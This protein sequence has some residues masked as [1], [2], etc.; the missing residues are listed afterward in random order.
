MTYINV[1][2]LPWIE[3]YRPHKINDILLEENVMNEIN[4]M[5]KNRNIPNMII[6][7][8]S[9]IGK[10][11][12]LLCIASR[13]YGKYYKESVLEINASDERGIKFVQDS[14][15]VFCKRKIVYNEKD[16]D[17]YANH[18]LIILDEADNITEKAQNII[19]KLIDEYNN[20]TKFVFTSNKSS[21]IIESIQSKCKILMFSQIKY[22][23]IMKRLAY[24]LNKE[25]IKY[26]EEGLFNIAYMS[27]GDLRHAINLTQLIFNSFGIINIENVNK[28]NELPQFEIIKNLLLDCL[29]NKLL[30][31]LNKI[32]ELKQKGFTGIDIL[33]SVLNS[34]IILNIYEKNKNENEKNKNI[35]NEN[36]NEKNKMKIIKIT[37]EYLYN[38]SKNIDTDLQ[39]SAYIIELCKINEKSEKNNKNNI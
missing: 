15:T 28:I 7:G 31:S 8:I 9:G 37:C 35:K 29:N 25:E 27:Q 21:C 4:N 30:L 38:I 14:M 13:L 19:S 6:T 5:I 16:K 11:T 12:T 36:I 20:T 10:T 32:K 26:D 34:L 3:K 17:K 2:L 24:I 18:K 22:T 1:E 39:L 33:S 23:S